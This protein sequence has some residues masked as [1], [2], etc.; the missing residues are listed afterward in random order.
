MAKTV[1]SFWSGIFQ[2]PMTRHASRSVTKWGEHLF[3]LN[4]NCL[5]RTLSYTISNFTGSRLAFYYLKA[6]LA[7]IIGIEYYQMNQRRA[8]QHCRRSGS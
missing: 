1:L 3:V 4:L 7:G 2:F 6:Q 5:N 8:Y